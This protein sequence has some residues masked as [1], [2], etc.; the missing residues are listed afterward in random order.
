MPNSTLVLIATHATPTSGAGHLMRLF[1]LIEVLVARGYEV[2]LYGEIS[3]QWLADRNPILERMGNVNWSKS[4]TTIIIDSYDSDFITGIVNRGQTKQMVQICDPST[5]IFPQTQ[6]V[7]LDP[8]P[9]IPYN[10]T[11]ILASGIEYFPS[12]ILQ[13]IEFQPTAKN[14]LIQLGGTPQWDMFQELLKFVYSLKIHNVD[15]FVFGPFS[16]LRQEGRVRQ[17]PLGLN[18]KSYLD[19]CDTVICGSGTSVWESLFNHRLVGV[20]KLVSNQESNFSFVVSNNFA[21]DLGQSDANLLLKEDN[22]VRLLL[23]SDLRLQIF[24]S[25]SEKFDLLG[26]DRLL[27]KIF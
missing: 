23:D 11:N 20:M 1:P 25:I 7:W 12:R 21:V 5:P 14:V 10:L 8:S 15:F 24:N 2:D 17:I 6:V 4:Y 9:S 13:E 16:E 19:I 27:A 18:M 22:L 3:I 26:V